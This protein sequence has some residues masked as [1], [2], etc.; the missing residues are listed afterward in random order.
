ML[1][2]ENLEDL[3]ELS[4]VQQGLLFHTLYE[5]Q[6]EVYFEQFSF[7]L[8]G[9]LDVSA[10]K[11]AWQQ[12]VD[13]H[14]ILRTCFYWEDL[15]KPYQVVHKQVK[16]P[17][18]ELDWQGLSLANQQERLEAFL[19]ADRAQG[20]NLSAAPLMRL[21]LI[22]LAEDNYQ[23]I[24]S[25]H[26]LLLDGWS[27][28]LLFQEVFAFYEGFRRGQSLDLGH[29]RPYRDY[30]NW[31][32]AQD[33]SQAEAFWRQALKGF[34][35]PTPLPLNRVPG[36]A[37]RQVVECNQ[38]HI[39]L[40]VATTTALQSLARQQ[41]L[42]MNTLVQG[43]WAL[44]LSRY[45]G[46]EDIVF[47]V[48][49][50]GR[51]PALAEVESMVGL[52]INTLPARVQVQ[53]EES[54]LRWLKKF[55]AQQ[56]ELRQYEYSPLIEI[57]RWSDMPRGLPLF[58]SFVAFQSYPVD[59]SLQQRC[60]ELTIQSAHNFSKTNYPL[61][62]TVRP[63]VELSLQITYDDSRFSTAAIA[64]ILEHL[65]VLLEGMLANPHQ[66]LSDLPLL[67]A[68][69]QQ[70]LVEWNQTQV[71]YPQHHC[72]HQLFEQ[73][74]ERS[75]D[76]VAVVF[77]DEQLTYRELNQR[78]NQLAHYLRASGVGAE[79]LV[80]IC[81]ER[82]VAMVVGLLGILKAGGAYLPLDP[83]YPAERLFFMLED[84]KVQVLL[85]Q[86]SLVEKLSECGAKVCLDT[87]WE[88]ITHESKDNPVSGST[89]EDLAYVIYTSGSTGKPK[90]VS[91]SH[92]NVIRLFEATQSWF[93]FNQQDVWTLFHSY[94]FDFSVW[95]LWGAL[96]YGGRLV[97]V[98]YWLSRSPA[99]FYDLLYTQQVT[100]LNQTPSAFRQL[101]RAEGNLEAAK[102]LTLRLVIFGGEALELQSLKPWFERH[103]D[104]S[105]QLVNMYGITETTVHVTYRPLTMADLSG[106]SGS[107]IGQPIPDL[108][109]YMLD[110]HQQPVP[111]G[112]PGEMHIGGAGLARGYLN[113]PDLT[114]EKFIPHPFSNRGARLYKSG[115]LA[116][117][118]PNGD[119]EYLGR[120]DHQVKVRGFRIELGEI[121]AVLAQHPAV[122]E[123]VVMVQ[124][125]Q[126]SDNLVAYV[127]PKTEQTP[128]RSE[129]RSFLKEKLP[130]Y[131]M[132]SAFVLLEALPLTLNGKVDR[133][134]LP[135]PSTA[136]PEL[137]E[138]F[139]APRTPQEQA[140]AEIWAQVLGLEQVGIY[141]NFFALG[142]DSIRSIQVQSQAQEQGLSFSLP[143][144]FQHQTIHQLAQELTSAET[145]SFITEQVQPF[146]LICEA[147]RLMVPKDVEDAYPLTML[148]MGMLFHS[149][150]TQDSS[151]F[152]DIFSFYLRA[153]LDHQVLQTA[154]R[155][156][157]TRHSTLRTSFNL[158]H[159]S[160][161]LQLVHQI[162]D[163]PLQT[164]DLRHLS[165][166]EQEKAVGAWIES[167][168]KK[169]FD[170]TR[171]PLLRFQVHYRTQETFQFTLS[172][173]HAILDGW[174]VASMLAELFQH[175]FFLLGKEIAPIP[176]QP[177]VGFRDFVAL[178]Q[179]A[180]RSE[181]CKQ[182]WIHKFSGSSK[183]RIPRY[184]SNSTTS[185]EIRLHEI[186]VSSEISEGLKR[187]AQ[188]A[189]VPLKSVLLAAHLRSISLLCD[190]SD[191]LTG[192]S[193]N[194]RPE[195]TDGDRILGLFLNTLP[196][197]L[198]LSGGTWIDLVR[199]TFASEREMLSFR[200]YP[201][202]Q[203]QRDLGGQHLFETCFNFTHFHVYQQLQQLSDLEVLSAIHF[204]IT[205]F[206]LLAD[207]SLDVNSSQIRLSLKFNPVEV[208]EKQAEDICHHYAKTLTAMARDPLESYG[209]S[210]EE[211][212]EQ[213]TKLRE[214]TARQLR[215]TQIR[216]M[217]QIKRKAVRYQD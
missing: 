54:L 36:S 196:F 42:T 199:E 4:P 138:A 47:G 31:L 2:V 163:V 61:G 159:F 145:S 83:A 28:S 78:A 9:N 208:G 178:Q 57:Q 151:V 204:E 142:G 13:R 174:S 27:L 157:L 201:M 58:E 161:P 202:A 104:Q 18:E 30:I 173:H 101:I 7:T 123:T 74:V 216:K 195:T 148:Q 100:V 165:V 11:R 88:K 175:Y 211:T 73:Q 45:S 192:I 214:D 14:P 112:I 5:P 188:S 158:T 115:D 51:P 19:Q 197:R 48:T 150:Y 72:I 40:S 41:Q 92:A 111:I 102:E 56:A 139:V 33:L 132:P 65:Q 122:Q 97:I 106:A 160:E 3:Y 169:H 181:E 166:A 52:F 26:H 17:W 200:W 191:V 186:S 172:F 168:K 91:I 16:F 147:D 59:A 113:R 135:V 77:A 164:E 167:E 131:M 80:G 134:V 198:K 12:V 190:Q 207:F 25:Y 162:V 118:L 68:V 43:A 152:H 82:S 137:A 39:K 69:E 79:E 109:V 70:L 119:I 64:R 133:R 217:Q 110:R 98:P 149:T 127:V 94:A 144:L 212:A 205:D 76:S 184:L 32:Q 153:P 71:D 108:Q 189:K 22:H 155:Q 24:W 86:Q 21:V 89:T 141:D 129:L 84:S 1:V 107:V 90:G 75:P 125:T 140:L 215:E 37:S 203:I 6:S 49:S 146:S 156:L 185:L 10:F 44:L 206:A 20:F 60:T 170:W 105:P 171:P 23:F 183:T 209:I 62:L 182:F 95:E 103:G 8:Q 120:I 67:T 126:P 154:I 130:E 213:I 116:R 210:G 85:T 176:P 136:R 34:T 15:D 194:G 143:Q 63:G 193:S 124:A 50:T 87:D 55:Q 177:E 114:A 81:V 29:P 93:H 53:P 96:L 35:A 179:Q 117:Y 180:L 121:E 38:Q 46:E 66:R 128:T 99:A 187:L